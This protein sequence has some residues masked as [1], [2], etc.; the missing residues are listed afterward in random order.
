MNLLF[1]T[2]SKSLAVF[3]DVM[4]AIG[5]RTDLGKVV[6]YLADAALFE[7]FKKERPSISSGSFELLKEWELIEKSRKVEPDIERLRDYE[8]KYGDPFL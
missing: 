5:E 4:Y 7:I 1:L 8:K 2:Q 3:Y 6:F